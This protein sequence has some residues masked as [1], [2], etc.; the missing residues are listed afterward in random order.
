MASSETEVED[1]INAALSRSTQTPELQYR[2]TFVESTIAPVSLFQQIVE[3]LREPR[4]TVPE[5]YYCG[6]TTLPATDMRPWFLDL[7]DQLRALF[8]KPKAPSIPIT[9]KPVDVPEIWQDYRPQSGSWLNSLLVH[10]VGIAIIM[11]PFFIQHTTTPVKVSTKYEMVDIS[12][13]L[14]ELKAAGKKAGG[15]GGRRPL[16]DA[17]FERRSS[18]VCEATTRSPAG[19]D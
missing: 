10:L 8:E 9:S 3:R 12:P 18:P 7:P 5:K 19:R 1:R 17:G 11:L 13:Y 15:G 14:A 2:L 6:Q 4:I 16:A